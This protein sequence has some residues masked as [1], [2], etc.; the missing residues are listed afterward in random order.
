MLDWLRLAWYVDSWESLEMVEAWKTGSKEG[1][2]WDGG[3][4]LREMVEERPE[5][6]PLD[7]EREVE[8]NFAAVEHHRLII[9]TL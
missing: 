6:T 7:P 2:A 5:R 4:S 3:Q 9:I 1:E 8:R